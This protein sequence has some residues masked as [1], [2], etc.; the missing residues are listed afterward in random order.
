M[1]KTF[2]AAAIAA[3]TTVSAAN[4]PASPWHRRRRRRMSKRTGAMATVVAA[5]VATAGLFAGASNSAEQPPNC[6]PIGC[7]VALTPTGPSP[8]ALTMHA[9]GHVLFYNPDSVS[10]T[11]VFANGRCSLTLAPGSGG[12]VD[13]WCRDPFMSYAGTYPYTVDGTFSGTVITTPLQRSVS[14]TARTH[15]IPPRARLTLRGQVTWKAFGPKYKP[16]FPVI[17]LARHQS[18]QPFTPVAAVNARYQG[19]ASPDTNGWKLTVRPR[20][21]TTYIAEVTGQFPGAEG[22]I[23]TPARSLPFTVRVRRGTR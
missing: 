16:P 4:Q 3:A 5:L 12:F 18:G 6:G 19:T 10:H 8:S 20:I 13:G 15:A 22:L 11:V 17:V 1:S 21:T 2:A 9:E 23:W 14:L 7:V